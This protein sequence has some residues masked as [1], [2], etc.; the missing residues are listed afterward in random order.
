MNLQRKEKYIRA[1]LIDNS[2]PKF[3]KKDDYIG[4]YVGELISKVES[5]KR[6]IAYASTGSFYLFNI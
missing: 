3:F 4:E 1:T 2:L 6:M 5:E